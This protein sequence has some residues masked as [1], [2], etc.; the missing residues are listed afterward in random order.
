[1]LKLHEWNGDYEEGVKELFKMV[2][3]D[4]ILADK[5]HPH[6]LSGGQKQTACLAMVLVLNPEVLIADEPTAAPDA[7]VQENILNLLKELRKD[8][9]ISII[10]ITYDLALLSEIS[11]RGYILYIDKVMENGSSEIIFKKPRHPY[12][13]ALIESIA[14]LYKDMV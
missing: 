8:L 5:Y 9:G 6:E 13:Q 10:F 12:T 7:M 14:T 4:P 1:M 3:I 11:N 2:N